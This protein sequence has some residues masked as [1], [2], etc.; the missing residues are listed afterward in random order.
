[1]AT[2][3]IPASDILARARSSPALLMTSIV[4]LR[5]APTAIPIGQRIRLR[6]R[7]GEDRVAR[8]DPDVAT[9]PPARR[10]GRGGTGS[11]GGGDG[12]AGG[13]PSGH[14]GGVRLDRERARDR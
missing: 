6:R 5:G 8:P 12:T 2:G 13:T 11:G 4:G 3:A 7:R 14:G 1:M 9:P 10:G